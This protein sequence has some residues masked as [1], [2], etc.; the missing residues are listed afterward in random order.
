MMS[1]W[2]FNDIRVSKKKK[3]KKKNLIINFQIFAKHPDLKGND[4]YDIPRKFQVHSTD[5]FGQGAKTNIA[6]W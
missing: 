2:C 4:Y 1:H 5:T 3:K 6:K